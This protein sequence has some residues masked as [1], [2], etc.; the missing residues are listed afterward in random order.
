MPQLHAMHILAGDDA[1]RMLLWAT[2][3]VS[4]CTGCTIVFKDYGPEKPVLHV[5]MPNRLWEEFRGFNPTRNLI[6]A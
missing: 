6:R 3:T 5:T 1:S 4:D 2:S